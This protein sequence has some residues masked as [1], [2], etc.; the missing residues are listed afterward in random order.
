MEGA[1]K[2]GQSLE[3]VHCLK[4]SLSPLLAPPSKLPA[5][6]E[7]APMAS[8]PPPR[9]QILGPVQMVPAESVPAR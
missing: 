1:G 5:W 7:P 2:S 4:M 6:E 3:S 8:P 9:P